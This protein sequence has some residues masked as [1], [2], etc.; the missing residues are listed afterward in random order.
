MTAQAVKLPRHINDT[1]K[2]D[3]VDASSGWMEYEVK[4]ASGEE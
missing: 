1:D 2:L 4:E 3:V